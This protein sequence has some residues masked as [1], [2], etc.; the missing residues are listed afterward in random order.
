MSTTEE[1][2]K[3]AG[4]DHM[5]HEWPALLEAYDDGLFRR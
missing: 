3:Q 5:Q 1:L 2:A 4:V